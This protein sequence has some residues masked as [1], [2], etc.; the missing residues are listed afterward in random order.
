MGVLI[1]TSYSGGKRLEVQH[2]YWAGPSDTVDCAQGPPS[3]PK[4]TLITHTRAQQQCEFFGQSEVRR[5][6]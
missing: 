3:P 5:F 6:T 1:D 2:H 4:V